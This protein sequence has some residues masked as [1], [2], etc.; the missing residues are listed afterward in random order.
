[1]DCLQKIII[2]C[3]WGTAVLLPFD[4]TIAL[5]G[6]IGPINASRKLFFYVMDVINKKIGTSITLVIPSIIP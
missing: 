3:L 6:S 5:L 4:S 2:A 1:M